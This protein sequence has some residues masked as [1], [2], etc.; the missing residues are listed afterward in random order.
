MKESLNIL[1]NLT[2]HT[3]PS[4]ME[5]IAYNT[6]RLF[7]DRTLYTDERGNLYC[8][9]G[10]NE[11]RKVLFTAHIDDV[12]EKVGKVKQFIEDDKYLT[13]DEKTILG[14]DNKTGCA[15]L[16]NMINNNI[17][18]TYY[19]F[20]EEEIGRKGSRWLADNSDKKFNLTIA[21]DRKKCGSIVTHQRGVKLSNSNLTEKLI[22]EFSSEKYEFKED[23]FGFS[24]DS[25]S[26]HE[27]S[28]NCINISNGT[29]NEHRK[30]EKVDLDYFDYMFNKVL[31]IDWQELNLLSREK[32]RE[33]LDISKITDNDLIKRILEFFMENGYRPN[34]SPEINEQFGLYK[35]DLYFRDESPR[36]FDY[37]KVEITA[38]GL[39]K[40]KG[41]TLTKEDALKYMQDYKKALFTFQIKKDFYQIGQIYYD[42][43]K[44][45]NNLMLIKN[46]EVI[47]I[48][49]DKNFNF[50]S[51]NLHN[52]SRIKRR[53]K[54][55]FKHNNLKELLK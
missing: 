26:F 22:E 10:N 25:Y 20:V 40:I 30:N 49:A 53:I 3:V 11:E 51:K 41:F 14:G 33:D 36:I 38:L 54:K 9:I 15:I 43:D 19:F 7:C 21:F 52:Y 46:D 8:E 55:H 47:K 44:G 28:N 35:Q 12:S 37:F 50:M 45:L 24:S 42:K 16:I 13:S 1:L 29:Y 18:G 2:A 31:D 6:I 34:K 23:L 48:Q 27:I 32:V 4:K 17:P 5:Y 39:I